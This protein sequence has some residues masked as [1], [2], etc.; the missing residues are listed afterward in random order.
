MRRPYHSK[1]FWPVSFALTLCVATLLAAA[2]THHATARRRQTTRATHTTTQAK[3]RQVEID[4]DRAV[5][6]QLPE[7]K[8][9]LKPVAFKTSDGRSGWAVNLPGGLPIA[10]P[11][12]AGG[13]VF[14]G[15]GYGSHE[16]YAF[17]ARTGALRWK[18]NTSDDGPTA[19]VV[20]D[21]YVAFNTESCTVI[22]VNAR[23]GKLVWQKWLGDPLMSQPAIA[24]GRLYIAYPAGQRGRGHA[25]TSHRLL[26]ADLRTGRRLWEQ[27]ITADVI[28]AP[29]ISGDKVYLTCFDGTSFALNAAHGT[30]IWR[31]EN[32]STSAPV[33]AGEQV[34]ITQKET[35]GHDDYEGLKRVDARRG[36]EHDAQL[37]ARE[38]ADYLNENKGGALKPAQQAALDS[39]VGFGGGAPAEANIAAANTHVGVNTVAG[40]W[41]YQGSRAAVKDGNVLNAQGRYINSVGAADGRVRWRAEVKGRDVERQAQAFSPP[42]LGERNMYLTSLVGHVI[43]IG[44]QDGAARF[45]YAFGQPMAFQPMLAEGNIYAG[46][47]NGLLIC[48]KTGDRDADGWY[49]WG[50]NAQHNKN[51]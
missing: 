18:V 35:R 17:D 37:I 39:S 42:A 41:A 5:N 16:F 15:G 3:P 14:V 21:G 29:V 6:V 30:V 23:T 11:A 8:Q 46:T 47:A 49:A 51:D 45:I 22:V 36:V 34:I 12:Y 43:A 26:C 32:Q 2:H 50:G 7:F 4:L 48:L 40:G 33:I 20:E 44:Q 25:R 13:L 31:K 10:T 24:Q 27:D 1:T 28:S 19:A 9:E 38:Q